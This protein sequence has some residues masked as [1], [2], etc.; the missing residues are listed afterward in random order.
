MWDKSTASN[1][2]WKLRRR[3]YPA[4]AKTWKGWILGSSS[5]FCLFYHIG[6]AYLD[7]GLEYMDMSA[8]RGHGCRRSDQSNSRLIRYPEHPNTNR[9][10]RDGW[11]AYGVV[12]LTV[13]PVPMEG[14]IRAY[15]P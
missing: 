3:L 8:P 13:I 10:I 12:S 4:T 15:F 6:C 14:D 5:Y 2:S 11:I 9:N 1:T 7:S